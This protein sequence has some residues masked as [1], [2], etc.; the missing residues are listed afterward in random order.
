[1]GKDPIVQLAGELADDE[2]L[3]IDRAAVVTR[4]PTVA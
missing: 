2:E 1:L 3:E 4:G